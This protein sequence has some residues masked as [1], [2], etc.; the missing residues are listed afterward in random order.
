MEDQPKTL[1]SKY[2]NWI[3]G[4]GVVLFIIWGISAIGGSSSKKVESTKVLA[5]SS[6]PSP[7]SSY[8]PES[9][10]NPTQKPGGNTNTYGGSSS[11]GGDKDC[12][13][14][15]TH[16]EAQAFF[17]AAGPGDPHRLDRDGDGIACETLP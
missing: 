12:S 7:Q 4:I 3:I 15:S 8:P 9:I 11:S 14:F 6:T 5:P 1:I 13:D 10:I 17:E 2:K 16:A